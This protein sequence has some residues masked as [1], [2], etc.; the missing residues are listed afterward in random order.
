LVLLR[1]A[2]VAA[3][4]AGTATGVVLV[5]ALSALYGFWLGFDNYGYDSYS[6]DL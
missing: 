2:E 4:Q 1:A 6:K 5:K 3:K